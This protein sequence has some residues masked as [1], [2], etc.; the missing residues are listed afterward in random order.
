VRTA[1]VSGKSARSGLP[2]SVSSSVCS[3]R[4]R[5]LRHCFPGFQADFLAIVGNHSS[6]NFLLGCGPVIN[7][8]LIMPSRRKERSNEKK[9]QI[10]FYGMI[11]EPSDGVF[12]TRFDLKS[13][14]SKYLTLRRLKSLFSNL[15]QS[16]YNKHCL[17]QLKRPKS[18]HYYNFITWSSFV[19]W[20]LGI[21]L[22]PAKLQYFSVRP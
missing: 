7:N 11:S 2:T 3:S 12:D 8:F 14:W 10:A 16:K 9:F 19:S 13:I 6:Q 22:I 4:C 17:A 1:S 5:Y 15:L 20:R 18:A 21:V